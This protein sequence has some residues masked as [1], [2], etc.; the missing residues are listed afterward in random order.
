MAKRTPVVFV[1]GLWLHAA[2]WGDWLEHFRTAGYA[3]VAPGWP[4]DPETVAEARQHP[5]RLAGKGLHEVVRHYAELIE[6]LPAKPIVVGHSFG[7]LIAQELL[8]MDLVAGAVSVDGVQ[9]K[10]V[11]PLPFE[12]LKSAFPV[13]MNPVNFGRAVMLTAEQFHYAFGNAIPAEESAALY[14][15]WVIPAPGKPLFETAVANF[16]PRSAATVNTANV[17]RGPL[18]L[19]GGGKDHTVPVVVTRANLKLYHQAPAATDLREF[20]DRGHSL[21]ID[22]GWQAVAD[23]VLEWL[24]ERGL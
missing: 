9:P 3:P 23:Y 6:Q 13:L 2:S 12:Q 19:I 5:E 1:H 16:N 8:G 24:K 18:L 15:R 17:T 4:G 21:T 22:H 14:E 7:G 11:L 10:G 20:E